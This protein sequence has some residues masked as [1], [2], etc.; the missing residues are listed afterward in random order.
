MSGL[1]WK[2]VCRI[3]WTSVGL[4]RLVSES[5]PLWSWGYLSIFLP[6]LCMTCHVPSWRAAANE[7]V[8]KQLPKSDTAL[9]VLWNEYP[10][11]TW[12]YSLTPLLVYRM[13]NHV[14]AVSMLKKIPV[15]KMF[16]GSEPTF[17]WH[18]GQ[19][20]RGCFFEIPIS[21]NIVIVMK[22]PPKKSFYR[23]PASPFHKDLCKGDTIDNWSGRICTPPLTNS[24]QTI[25]WIEITRMNK[26]LIHF[27]TFILS[28]APLTEPLKG[29]QQRRRPKMRHV[30]RTR[31]TKT[32]IN[33]TLARPHVS[34]RPCL[35]VP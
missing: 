30:C 34:I 6:Y 13:S 35:L 28:L 14:Q 23:L 3:V 16:T 31:P 20:F 25:I 12:F 5:P 27:L 8:R 21:G 22:W 18:E 32:K 24:W 17:L 9:C 4:C 29:W 1:V 10:Y 15:Y 26:M 11:T 33:K 2:Y 7:H 19:D